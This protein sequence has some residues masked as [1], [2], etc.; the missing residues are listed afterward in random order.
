MPGVPGIDMLNPLA[1][2]RKGLFVHGSKPG[3]MGV[4]R[5]NAKGVDGVGA[6]GIKIFEDAGGA[7]AL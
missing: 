6:E 1:R 7:S 3:N 4:A 5:L 2:S